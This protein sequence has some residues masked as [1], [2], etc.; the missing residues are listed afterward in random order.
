MRKLIRLLAVPVIVVLL[1]G[2][3]YATPQ[4]SDPGELKGPVG[5]RQSTARKVYQLVRYAEQGA[6]SVPL[7]SGEVVVWDTISDDGVT[8]DVTTTS[9]DGSIAG[10]AVTSFETADV[11]GPASNQEGRRNWGFIQVYGP[12]L[13]YVNRGGG[14]AYA[15]GDPFI[16]SVDSGAVTRFEASTATY[17]N[18]Q[19]ITTIN[20]SR[21][22]GFFMDAS[23]G[24]GDDRA[25]VFIS[26]E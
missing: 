8:I 4:P 9:A 21:K 23:A 13:A 1:G 19:I 10:I 17:L 24:A 22:G 15:A 7:A 2:I 5:L 6:T 11:I 3:A 14:N 20:R 26:L 25:E 18:G 16:T 12:A